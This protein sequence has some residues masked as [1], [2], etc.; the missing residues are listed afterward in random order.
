M[1]TYP[2]ASSP[3]L[4]Q[5][6]ESLAAQLEFTQSSLPEV[7]RLLHVLTSHITQGQIG[8]IGSGCGVGAAWIV[9]ALHPDSTLITIESD[10]QLAKVVQQLFANKSN[11]RTLQGDWHD[12]L[13]YAPFNLL[14][15]DGG[16][17]KLTE[18][19]T[20]ITALKLGGFILLDDLTPEEY[21]PPQWHGRTDQIREFWLKDPRI[22]ATEIPVTAKNSVILATRIQ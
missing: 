19:Q 14:F 10:R 13:T 8:E 15:A 11:V 12:L 1:T 3:S 21:W 16:K 9:S 7:G 18:P 17:A 2:I 20:L 6:A 5:Q 4:V 22:A